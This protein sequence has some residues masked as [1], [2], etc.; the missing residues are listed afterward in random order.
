MR[1]RPILGNQIGAYN[2]RVYV[3]IDGSYCPNKSHHFASEI[4]LLNKAHVTYIY[5]RHACHFIFSK[6]IHLMY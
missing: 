4:G 2:F 1:I 3:D 6:R 5:R